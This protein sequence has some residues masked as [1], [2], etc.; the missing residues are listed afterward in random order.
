MCDYI[1]KDHKIKVISFIFET[2]YSD[3]LSEKILSIIKDNDSVDYTINN[4]GIFINL[5]FLDS[6]ILDTI[7]FIV[8]DYEKEINVD[9]YNSVNINYD[10]Y[11]I[12][13]D[14]D[15]FVKKEDTIMYNDVDTYL[16]ELSTQFLTI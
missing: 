2:K 11:P 14:I 10:N 4:N 5:N 1:D 7:Y 3:K 15:T 6:E 16:L 9:N 12:I 8:N 13:D